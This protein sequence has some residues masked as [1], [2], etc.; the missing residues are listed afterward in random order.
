MKSTTSN[1]SPLVKNKDRFEYNDYSKEEVNLIFTVLESLKESEDNGYQLL[2][3]LTPENI[4]FFE[5]E[6][7]SMLEVNGNLDYHNIH[8]LPQA[9]NELRTYL[10]SFCTNFRPAFS[11]SLIKFRNSFIYTFQMFRWDAFL[12]FHNFNI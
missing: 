3:S 10:P 7:A 4:E 2:I 9:S 11:Q 5:A 6:I 1:K 12:N 8:F